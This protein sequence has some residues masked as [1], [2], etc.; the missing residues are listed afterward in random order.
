MGSTAGEVDEWKQAVVRIDKPFYMSRH[1]ITNAQFACADPGHDSGYISVFNKDHY[2]RGR[3]ANRPAQPAVRLSWHQAMAFCEWLSGRAGGTFSLP[4]EAQWEY[5][6]RAGTASPLYYGPADTD[7]G[8]LANLADGQ[9]N[10]LTIRD[11]PNW[12]PCAARVNDGAV[13]SRDVGGYPPNAWGLLD[14]HGN[15]AEWTLS[16]Y[17]RYPYRDADGRNDPAARGQRVVRGGSWRDRP[18]RARSAFR[19]A[20]PAWQQVFNV[21]F[22]VVCEAGSVVDRAA[23]KSRVAKR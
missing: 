2:N 20:Y 16:L 8:K 15:A 22:R 18:H 10:R 19:L 9:V 14:M 21:G 3:A 17:R 13:V 11:S 1:E 7:F 23:G 6:C 12:I 4:T 5:A